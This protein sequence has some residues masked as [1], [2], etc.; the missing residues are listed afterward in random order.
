MAPQPLRTD[1]EVRTLLADAGLP[2][3]D[4]DGPGAP[5]LFGLRRAGALVAAV[6]I[7]RHGHAGLLRSLVVAPDA[8][9]QGLAG[10]LVDAAERWAAAQDIV[11]LYLLTQTAEAFFARRG[12]A[13]LARERAPPAIAATTQFAGLCPGTAA[14]MA[15]ALPE[16]RRRPGHP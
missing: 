10:L 5:T 1:A 2:V 6:G 7:E 14:F 13:R 15:K 3:A 9:G 4:L 8:R 11:T 16:A 12:Y